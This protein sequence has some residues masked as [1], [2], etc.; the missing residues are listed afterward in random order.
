MTLL[1]VAALG[2][3]YGPTLVD[4]VGVWVTSRYYNHG[5]LVPLFSAWVAWTARADLPRVAWD[6]RPAGGALLALAL[7]ALAGGT[8]LDSL[9]LR[10]LSLPLAL[11][12]VVVL[13]LGV[14]GLRRL[15]FPVGFLA[16]MAPLPDGALTRLSL[17]M[18]ELA[19]SV[20]DAALAGLG[21]PVVR[22]GLSLHLESVTL[23]ITE[24][25][26]GLRFLFTM[27]VIGVAVAWAVGGPWRRRGAI[28]GLALVAGVV[29]NLLRV[30]GTAVIAEVAGP[31]AVL[32]TPHLV[33][34]K[35]VYGVVFVAFGVLA[36]VLAG[37]RIRLIAPLSAR[38]A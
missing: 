35:A 8:A 5:L 36:L 23:D 20:T 16:L 26:N 15:T 37:V 19:T 34:G 22:Q 3:L 21:V 4:L 28:V 32:G 27:A 7:L 13:A 24:E 30:L 31:A 1:V 2:A 6:L 12:A 18:Q 25:C 29:A 17:A 11:A 9:T 14:R 33:F 38:R 10:A